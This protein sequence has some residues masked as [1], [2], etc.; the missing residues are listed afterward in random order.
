MI[1]E[2]IELQNY[3]NYENLKLSFGEKNNI[4]YGDNARGKTNL[5]EAIFFRGK[6]EVLSFL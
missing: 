3:R 1:I 2:S 5:L 4:F 6:Y